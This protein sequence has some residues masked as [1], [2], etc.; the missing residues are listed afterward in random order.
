MFFLRK[1]KVPLIKLTLI[2]SFLMIIKV[3]QMADYEESKP[4]SSPFLLQFGSQGIISLKERGDRF[5]T[6]FIQEGSTLGHVVVRYR[7]KG[8][9]WQEFSTKNIPPTRRRIISSSP[10]NEETTPHFLIIYN[11]SGWDDYFADLEFTQRFRVMG[12]ALYW[13]LHL[14]NLTHKPLEIGDFILELPF[15]TQPRWD[16]EIMYTK[17]VYPHQFISGHGSFIFWMRPNS[18]GRFLLMTPVQECPLFEDARMERNFKPAKLEY[19]DRRGV[20]LH[21]KLTIDEAIKKGGNWRQDSTSLILTPKFSPQDEITYIFKFTWVDGYQGVR[22]ALV[23]NNLFDVEIVPGMTLPLN[24]AAR[25][26]IRTKNNYNLIPEF[27]THTQI[28]KITEKSSGHIIYRVKFNKLGEN[29]ITVSWDDGKRMFLEFFITQPLE[30]LIKKRASFLVNKQQHRDPS[31]W[32]DGLF[33]EWDMKKKILL[34]PDKR[35]GLKRYVLSCDDP[36]LGK[37]PYV[38]AKNVGWPEPEEIEAVEYYIKNFVWG[39]LQRT[40]QETYPYGVYGI[41]DWKTN[42]EAGPTDREGWVGHL[43]RV[44]DY[45]HVI[46]LYWSMYRL[47]QFYPE[48]VHYLDADGYLERALGTA[49]AYFTLPLELAHWSALDLGTMDEMVINFLIQDL[50]KRG[51]KEKAEW[52]K[53]RWEKKIE[54]F[55]K[56]DPNLFHSEYPFDPTGFEAYHALAKYAYHQLKEGNS[57]LKVTLDEVKQFMEKEIALNIATR[58]WLETSYYQ[59]GGE[60]RLRYM[61]QM[62]G[63]SILD[64]GLYYAENLYPFLRLGY[65][66]FLS[67]WALMNAGD[68]ESNYGYWW[69]VKE[70]DGAAGSAF[71]TEAYGRTWLGNEQKRGAWRYSAEIDLGFGAAL[72]TAATII[73]QDPLFGL[74]CYGGK[75]EESGHE[76]K[77][78]SLDGL[79]QR[80]HLIKV[81]V[82]L[83]MNLE[84]DGFTSSPPIIIHKNLNYLKFVIESRYEQPHLTKLY[85]DGLRPGS[86]RVVIDGREKDILSAQQLARGV[87]IQVENRNIPVEIICIAKN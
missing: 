48:L 55:I 72:R 13:T 76:L 79:R 26:A 8:G 12:Q 60:K 44:F 74:I 35:D 11:E 80:F 87:E 24:L 86:Y 64:Y 31:K 59:L 23:E 32:Y 28:E 57:T 53:R 38:A 41:P 78:Y 10:D 43:W 40:N 42:R 39:K 51:W 9:K 54:H 70:N 82:K 16:K 7:M 2:I 71:V 6:E 52:L 14:R 45:P 18:Q 34:N 36:G 66:S 69:P 5:D 49:K 37:A 67:S 73:A 56:D 1:I 58:G 19:I 85:L 63:W 3:P 81:H 21:S 65:A 46:N 27:P 61:S 75:L 4:S 33:S 30:T 22:D 68:E 77:I 25:L 29:K 50:E 62:G 47:A 84:R 20:Y 15:N 83:H 17:R